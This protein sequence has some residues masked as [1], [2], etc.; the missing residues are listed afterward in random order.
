MLSA[1]RPDDALRVLLPREVG[2]EY[3]VEHRDGLFYIRTNSGGRNFRLVTAP[4]SAPGRENWKEIADRC[5]KALDPAMA[6]QPYMQGALR[7]LQNAR[8]SLETAAT[9]K[10]GHRAKAIQLVDEAIRQVKVGV[11]AAR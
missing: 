3:S 5:D 6:D 2:H 8:A 11:A 4:V 1:D 9:D 10:G 7:A